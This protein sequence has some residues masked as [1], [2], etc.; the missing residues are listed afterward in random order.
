[1]ASAYTPQLISSS[2]L[3]Y[4]A[5]EFIEDVHMK[6]MVEVDLKGDSLKRTEETRI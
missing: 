3:F 6:Y 2:G 1:M 5:G 4:M